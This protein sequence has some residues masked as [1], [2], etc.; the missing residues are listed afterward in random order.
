[1]ISHEPGSDCEAPSKTQ[2]K[3]SAAALQTLG[4]ELVAL[5][6]EQLSRLA[7]PETL[8]DAVRDAQRITSHEG[9]RRQ[10]QYIGKLMRGIDPAPIQTQLDALKAVPAAEVARMHRIERWR[11]RLIDDADA[12]GAFAAEF[13]QADLQQLRTLVRNTRHEREAG[14]P[15]KSYRA[16]FQWLR[17]IIQT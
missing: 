14:K 10:L 4:T 5:G 9:R 11:D 12:I 6:R 7:L 16:M 3:N 17:D 8:Y 13:P 15:P 2:R 1:M